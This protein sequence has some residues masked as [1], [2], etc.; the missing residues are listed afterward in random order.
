MKFK[1]ILKLLINTGKNTI[2]YGRLKRLK[3]YFNDTLL[4]HGD[5]L[6][7]INLKKPLNLFKETVSYFNCCKTPTIGVIKFLALKYFREKSLDAD[8]KWG[9]VINQN[10]LIILKWYYFFRTGAAKNITK[11]KSY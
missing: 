1:K 8:D 3:N 6:S 4:T 11:K 5:G 10:L 7:N 9:F 2:T